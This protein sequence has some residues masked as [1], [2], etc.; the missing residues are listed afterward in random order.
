MAEKRYR[1]L[2]LGM[3]LTQDFFFSYTYSVAATLQRNMTAGAQEH[4]FDSIHIWNDHLSRYIRK[5]KQ[6]CFDSI[7]IWTDHL[8][9][10]IRQI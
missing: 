1:K 10:Y 2:L 7:H 9:R 4:R 3:D 6:H 5:L 8:S